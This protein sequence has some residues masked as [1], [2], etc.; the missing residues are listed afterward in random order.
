VGKASCIDC[1]N[2]PMLTDK[3][4]HNI[5]I[6]QVG[7]HVP[8]LADCWA[9]NASCDC[10]TEG[11]E[12]TCLPS[13]AWGGLWKLTLSSN[14]LRRTSRWGDPPDVE[15][16]DKDQTLSKWYCSPVDQSLKGAWRTPSLRDVATTA[17]YMHDGYY[18]T[19]ED[20]LWHY[21]NGGTASG[22]DDFRDSGGIS[23]GETDAGSPPC[24]APDPNQQTPR[25]RAAQIK[26]LGLT[27]DEVSDL[28]EFLKT[29]SGKPLY[30]NL[31]ANPPDAP[32]PNAGTDAG[33]DGGTDAGTD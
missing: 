14:K 29:L 27:A 24:G 7:D 28:I 12:D 17:P 25:S 33:A 22:S 23:N 26:P 18:R 5:G 20:V 3:S 11:K 16:M 19:L 30:P 21:N 15:A 6:P 10:E 8:T 1:H 9:G 32:P 13:G 4:F 31:V 2:G